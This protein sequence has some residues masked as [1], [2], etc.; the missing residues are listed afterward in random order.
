MSSVK[1]FHSKWWI[2]YGSAQNWTS[3][4]F[5]TKL[6]RTMLKGFIFLKDIFIQER[7][8]F[9]YGINKIMKCGIW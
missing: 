5:F 7:F 3:D 8:N 2:N 1:D 4:F 6:R 9:T